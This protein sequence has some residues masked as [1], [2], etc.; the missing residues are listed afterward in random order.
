MSEDRSSGQ[1]NRSWIEKLLGALSSD[2]DEPSSRDEL[3]EFLRQAAG[4]LK[5]EQ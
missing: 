2:S 3:L 5:L 4:R 1:G